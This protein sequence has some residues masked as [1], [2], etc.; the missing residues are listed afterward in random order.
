MFPFFLGFFK[1]QNVSY[2][3]DSPRT[4][5]HCVI[6]QKTRIMSTIVWTPILVERLITLKWWLTV[7]P[8]NCQNFSALQSHLQ[9]FS[10]WMKKCYDFVILIC[11]YMY[12]ASC[13]E[14]VNVT[15]WI[16]DM[17]HA[18][19]CSCLYGFVF[20]LVV[21]VVCCMALEFGFCVCRFGWL[22]RCIWKFYQYLLG[23]MT[24]W[25][26]VQRLPCLLLL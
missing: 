4:T 13:T 21:L 26:L 14:C 1:F 7:L 5:K 20:T 15:L 17:L 11:D 18:G 22:G 19:M 3:L 12:F 9:K 16:C 2:F 10:E 25:W 24:V 8:L 23:G 6:S